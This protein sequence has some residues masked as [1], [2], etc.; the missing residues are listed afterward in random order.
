MKWQKPELS[1]L[2]AF[3]VVKLAPWPNTAS[4]LATTSSGASVTPQKLMVIVFLDW[5]FCC[6][7]SRGSIAQVSESICEESKGFVFEMYS[8]WHRGGVYHPNI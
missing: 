2:A 1:L 5:I 6:V 7:P 3:W 8:T 4:R